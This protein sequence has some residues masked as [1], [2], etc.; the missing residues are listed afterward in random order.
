[1]NINGSRAC[2]SGNEAGKRWNLRSVRRDLRAELRR[3][4]PSK[5]VRAGPCPVWGA[6][7]RRRRSLIDHPTRGRQSLR[8]V[9]DLN[10]GCKEQD[11]Q[12]LSP[13]RFGQT[14]PNSIMFSMQL[15]RVWDAVL[16]RRHILGSAGDGRHRP[17]GTR[18]PVAKNRLIISYLWPVLAKRSQI[19]QCFQ[20]SSVGYATPP[21]EEA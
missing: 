20:C 12:C 5:H 3:G 9:V 14:K 8:P 21:E 1:M 17:R 11:E 13:S 18:L 2:T 6:P 4:R 10:Q 16:G 7:G 19:R 15:R